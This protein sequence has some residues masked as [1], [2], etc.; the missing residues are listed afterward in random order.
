MK[1]EREVIN[2]MYPYI[3]FDD[4]TEVTFSQIIINDDKETIEVHF[5]RPTELGFDMARCK[6]PDYIW[7]K[8]EG[9]N[10]EEI[11][12]FEEFLEHNVHLFYKYAK[13]GGIRI[14]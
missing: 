5:E 12:N 3:K 8:K 13:E 11:K 9:Y 2:M 7:I 10:D 14:A 1:Y 6:L 4:E